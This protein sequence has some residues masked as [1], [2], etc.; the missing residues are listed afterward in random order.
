MDS[1]VNG[2]VN[3]DNNHVDEQTNQHHNLAISSIAWSL[4]LSIRHYIVSTLA[5]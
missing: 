4:F 3:F 1:Q 5:A 2:N